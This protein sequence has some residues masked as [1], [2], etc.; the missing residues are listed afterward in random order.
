MS[1]IDLEL[2]HSYNHGK[3]FVSILRSAAQRER[4]RKGLGK[5]NYCRATPATRAALGRA[6]EDACR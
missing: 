4:R 1:D 2:L 5:G 3:Q 6:L